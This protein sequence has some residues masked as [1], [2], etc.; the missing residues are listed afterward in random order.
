MIAIKCSVFIVA[1]RKRSSHCEV[2]N[3][4]FKAQT[5]QVL[6]QATESQVQ[7]SES[8][9]FR[10]KQNSTTKNRLN[11]APPIFC[12]TNQFFCVDYSGDWINCKKF[13][14]N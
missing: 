8:T 4:K 5:D 2:Q 9:A 12:K 6:G 1:A 3:L 14:Q 10:L 7:I 13:E 11:L